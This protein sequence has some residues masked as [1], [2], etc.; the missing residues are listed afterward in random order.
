MVTLPYDYAI[1]DYKWLVFA[2]VYIE[3]NELWAQEFV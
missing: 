3:Q 2:T 1:E